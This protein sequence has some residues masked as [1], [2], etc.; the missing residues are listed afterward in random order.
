MEREQ[1]KSS[2]TEME[3]SGIPIQW[4]ALFDETLVSHFFEAANPN[5]P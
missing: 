2:L 4:R 5:N 3:C 1:Q